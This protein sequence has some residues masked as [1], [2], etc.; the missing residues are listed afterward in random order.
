MLA[1]VKVS[2][3]HIVRCNTANVF[4]QPLSLFISSKR[5]NG[6]SPIIFHGAGLSSL[7]QYVTLHFVY[8][9]LTGPRKSSQRISLPL[10]LSL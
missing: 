10:R 8:D 3:V 7:S 1:S 4:I 5:Q 6:I 9:T 2:N